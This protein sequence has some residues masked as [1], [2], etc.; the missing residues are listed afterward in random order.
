MGKSRKK[1]RIEPDEL[2]A[3]LRDHKKWVESSRSEGARADLSKA[4]LHKADMSN[5]DLSEAEL[6][7]AKLVEANL[8]LCNLREADLSKTDLTGAS[9]RMCNLREAD[10]S[11][12]NLTGASLFTALLG[13]ADLSGA[14]LISAVLYQADLRGA[15]LC[16]VD[17]SAAKM[18]ALDLSKMDLRGATLKATELRD[19]D[20]SQTNLSGANLRLADL[21][22][23]NLSGADLSGT[24]LTAADLSWADLRGA[25][26][27]GASCG[28]TMLVGVNFC[29]SMNLETVRHENPSTIDV[30]TLFMSEGK[31]PEKF[32]RGCGM[33]P[34]E[35]FVSR[36]YDPGMTPQGI[37]DYFSEILDLRMKRPNFLR[38]VYILHSHADASFVD[39][40]EER[41]WNEGA[42]VWRDTNE[43]KAQS[44]ERL[45]VDWA[46]RGDAVVVVLSKALINSDW[47][48]LRIQNVRRDEVVKKRKGLIP[49]AIDASWERASGS[50]WSELRRGKAVLDFAR[51]KT[52]ALEEPF[53]R[54]VDRL[55]KYYAPKGRGEESDAD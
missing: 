2:K 26:L 8:I 21:R 27:S 44:L 31:I 55:E 36:L 13:G 10:L 52:E 48:S 20:L 5:S 9:L 33:R 16:G 35:V 12:A 54:L 4:V 23:A 32:L 1:R 22:Q 40:L 39:K 42:N 43:S 7:G 38:G 18:R 41:L 11:K 6:S 17:L 50:T 19:V 28:G 34:W 45:N 15:N 49:I 37:H 30:D 14:D 46:V 29:G 24:D 53:R 3:I 51:W 47:A 25:D